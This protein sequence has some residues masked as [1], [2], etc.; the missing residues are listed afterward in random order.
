[1]NFKE[2]YLLESKKEHSFSS[3]LINFDDNDSKKILSWS[4]RNIP[5]SK[6]VHNDNADG[7]ETNTHVTVL[8]GLHN[9]TPEKVKK[10]AKNIKP[11]H[12][13]LGKISKF[14]G[15]DYDVIKIEVIGSDLIKAN[16]TIA[17]LPHTNKYKTYVPHCTIAYVKKGSCDH[18]LGK[19]IFKGMTIPVNSI[20]FSSK[21]REKTK[22]SL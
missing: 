12:I 16:K 22:I 8:Y 20:V 4:R 15:L 9:D 3:V 18:L 10:I 13:K 14:E 2:W 1:M 5:S 21:T 17:K 6:L 7:R 11:F 19:E